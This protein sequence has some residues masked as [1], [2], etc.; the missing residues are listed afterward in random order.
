M[1][2]PKLPKD[3]LTPLEAETVRLIG[4][5]YTVRECCQKL[6]RSLNA[7]H[8]RTITARQKIG[9]MSLLAL[10]RWAN[11]SGL[12]DAKPEDTAGGWAISMTGFDAQ[13]RQSQKGGAHVA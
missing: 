3:R 10:C 5:G 1:A 7:V 6:H 11:V 12:A 2:R 13:A 9:V 8:A 4:L